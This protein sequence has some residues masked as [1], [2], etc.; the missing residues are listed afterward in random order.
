MAPRKDDVF[1]VWQAAYEKS[2]ETKRLA[3]TGLVARATRFYSL[4]S[5]ARN[6]SVIEL[7]PPHHYL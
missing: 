7:A 6:N 4:L 3:M 1:F 5:R 2:V